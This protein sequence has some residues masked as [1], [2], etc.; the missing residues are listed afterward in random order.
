LGYGE[1]IEAYLSA[2]GR[3]EG[4]DVKGSGYDDDR[5]MA[6]LVFYDY[7]L[8]VCRQLAYEMPPGLTS[9]TVDIARQV[10]GVASHYLLHGLRLPRPSPQ[11]SAPGETWDGHDIAGLYG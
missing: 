11:P 6:D 9:P 5:S 4:S 1:V 3:L 2:V 7:L 8:L 10:G